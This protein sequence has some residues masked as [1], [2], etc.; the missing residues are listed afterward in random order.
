MYILFY[1]N[2]KELNNMTIN[3]DKFSI[4]LSALNHI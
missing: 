3:S 1:D 4:C 2:D